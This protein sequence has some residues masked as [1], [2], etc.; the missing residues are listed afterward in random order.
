MIEE[1]AL[2]DYISSYSSRKVTELAEQYTCDH[3]EP[4]DLWIHKT[5]CARRMDMSAL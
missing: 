4:L 3:V 1:H 2:H 5:D